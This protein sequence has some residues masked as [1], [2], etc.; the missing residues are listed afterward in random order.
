VGDSKLLIAVDMFNEIDNFFFKIKCC[1]TTT[2]FLNFVRRL[3]NMAQVDFFDTLAIGC[4]PPNL[5][6]LRRGTLGMIWSD[7]LKK[8]APVH[9]IEPWFE[10]RCKFPPVNGA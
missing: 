7:G 9:D 2:T 4:W 5:A 8:Y 6:V 3:S 1:T 10:I